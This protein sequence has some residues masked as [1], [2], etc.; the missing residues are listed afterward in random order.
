M[1]VHDTARGIVLYPVQQRVL[2]VG[3]DTNAAHR[4]GCAEILV[5]LVVQQTVLHVLAFA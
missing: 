5:I 3:A 4:L 1:R 2:I